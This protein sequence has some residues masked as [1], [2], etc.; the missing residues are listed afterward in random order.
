M[1]VLDEA[2][3]RL[4][5]ITERRL[6]RAIDRLLGNNGARR[7]AL[8]IAHRLQTVER[9]DD[10]LILERGRVVEF[11]PRAELAAD[12]NSR[13]SALLRTGMEEALA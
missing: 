5:P 1:V 12:P 8:I 2:A 3:S 13:F 6:E 9:A 4:D 10:I 11:G 7:T